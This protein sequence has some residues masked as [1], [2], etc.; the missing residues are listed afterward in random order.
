M[1]RPPRIQ[2]EGACYHVYHR[3]N[4]RERIFW[5]DADYAKFEGF[6]IEAMNWSGIRLFDWSLLPNHFHMFLETPGGNLSEFMQ[7]MLTRYA[8]YFNWRHTKVGHVF[9][10][11]YGAKVCDKES[12]FLELVRYVE[13]NPYRLKKGRLAKL[14][15]W[16]WSSLR[17][18]QGKEEAP[19]GMRRASR[20]YGRRWWR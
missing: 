2:F 18:Y 20:S 4:R 14:G 10:G 11:R 15:E 12:Y 19:E 8:K 9:P 7:R 6:M 3:G 17:F 1:G 13:L 16:K 5:E